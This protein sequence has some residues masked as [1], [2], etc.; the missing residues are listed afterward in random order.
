MKKLFFALLLA[1]PMLFTSC[2]KEETKIVSPYDD[3]EFDKR[4][5]V[6]KSDLV[7]M[8][9]IRN[10]SNNKYQYIVFREAEAA[11]LVT[12]MD[13]NPESY[14][15]SKQW[16]VS[17]NTLTI[18]SDQG[19]SKTYTI[20]KEYKKAGSVYTLYVYLNDDI[21]DAV[22]NGSNSSIASYFWQ[23]IESQKNPK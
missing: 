1:V 17:G 15:Y 23:I 18:V 2:T 9:V 13:S 20:S 11:I 6:T 21:Y 19:V 8:E 14:L 3:I 22:D 16:N 12:D 10:L 5:P 4:L 7:Q